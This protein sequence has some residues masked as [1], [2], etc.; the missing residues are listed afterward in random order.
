VVRQFE[1]LEDVDETIRAGHVLVVM[2][3][4]KPKEGDYI[5]LL[6]Q[7][8][9]VCARWSGRI[10]A[11]IIGVVGKIGYAVRPTVPGRALVVAGG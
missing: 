10:D 4:W 11:R 9:P 2:E 3:S 5:V 8:M 6:E 7:D 1:V